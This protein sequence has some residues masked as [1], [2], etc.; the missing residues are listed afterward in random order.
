[1]LIDN[2]P[3][4]DHELVETVAGACGHMLMPVAE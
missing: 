1:M 3:D 2:E 4:K